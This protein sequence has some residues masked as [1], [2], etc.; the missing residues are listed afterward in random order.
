MIWGSGESKWIRN[1]PD[2]G[3]ANRI[4]SGIDVAGLEEP[5]L[6]VVFAFK[7]A[8]RS[9]P[10]PLSL[11]FVTRYGSC[12]CWRALAT[13]MENTDVSPVVTL[14]AVALTRVPS[15]TFVGMVS[16]ITAAPAALVNTVVEP[17]SAAPFEI[18][19]IGRPPGWRRTGSGR[20]CRQ[21]TGASHQWSCSSCLG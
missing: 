17:I 20:P 14:V 1:G 19:R 9:E 11:V 4:W 6:G 10:D 16:K 15:G 18:A 7:I 8:W 12:S 5:E 21:L 13:Y 3:M 2:P